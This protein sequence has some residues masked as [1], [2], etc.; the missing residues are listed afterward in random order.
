MKQVLWITQDAP[1]EHSSEAGGKSFNYYF[2]YVERSGLADITLVALCRP[3]LLDQATRDNSQI[4]KCKLIPF[5][6]N[7]LTKIASS[8]NPISSYGG[9]IN[10]INARAIMDFLYTQ[11]KEGYSPDIIFLE[12]TSTLSLIKKIKKVF[13]AA[14]IVVTEHDVTYQ[15][16]LRKAE[17]FTGIKK[18]ALSLK[19][20]NCKRVEVASLKLADKI[21]VLQND[22]ATLIEKENVDSNKIDI[23]TPFFF[24]FSS[25]KRNPE[26]KQ[27]IFYGA[28]NREENYLSAI[29]FIDKVM[30]LLKDRE[31]HFYIIG[32][33][34]PELL[35]KKSSERIHIC[36]F[37][38]SLEEVFASCTC[39]VAPLVLG[40]GIKV[41]ILEALS[42]GVP[43]LGNEIAFEGI[44]ITH[45]IQGLYCTTPEEYAFSILDIF[46]EKIDS[47]A[48]GNNGRNH[49]KKKFNIEETEK[50]YLE[51]LQD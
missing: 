12:W 48:I 9:L 13:P 31:I 50:K 30:P 27:I 28:M 20:K 33:N 41:K 35:R 37:V 18:F 1:I 22:N 23:I 36:G 40:A 42:A 45:K 49:I 11:K 34:P 47:V 19:A 14:S 38:S 7:D 32:G 10:P 4:K 3:S 26:K 5:R 15:S 44:D 17:Y 39:M 21:F 25:V 51:I 6:D 43:V 8:L 2:R 16:M 46:D 24:D 29:W